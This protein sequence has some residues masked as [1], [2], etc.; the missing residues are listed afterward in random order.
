M[1]K[2]GV[3]V[4]SEARLF[5]AIMAGIKKLPKQSN[6]ESQAAQILLAKKI[7]DELR[8][9]EEL[10]DDIISEHILAGEQE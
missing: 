10:E 6:M 7:I 9:E 5:D 3:W 1:I 2:S 4:F 8:E